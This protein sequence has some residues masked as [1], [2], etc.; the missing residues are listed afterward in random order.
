MSYSK[1]SIHLW[2]MTTGQPHPTAENPILSLDEANV[3]Y[4]TSVTNYRLAVL[5]GP[6]L[7]TTTRRMVVWDWRT[8]RILLASDLSASVGLSSNENLCLCIGSDRSELP[9]IGV[10]EWAF[11]R[12]ALG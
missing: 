8:G 9:A 11:A 12:C 2:S 5:A 10:R 3:I 7:D 4:S 1:L 6:P